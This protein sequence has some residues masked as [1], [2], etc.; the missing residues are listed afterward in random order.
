MGRFLKFMAA[1]VIIT[2]LSASI[3]VVLASMSLI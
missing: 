1:V 2:I 3:Q